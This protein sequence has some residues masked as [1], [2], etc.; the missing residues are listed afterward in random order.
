MPDDSPQTLVEHLRELRARLLRCLAALALVL[1]ALAPFAAKLYSLLARPLLELLP[2]EGALIAT[3]VASPFL[4]PF[5]L[6]LA[7]A[8]FIT[9]PYWL[10]QAWSFAA[11]GMYKNEKRF[12]AG[13]LISSVA[14]FY[15]GTAFAAF[16][17]LPLALNFFIHAAPGDVVVMT[18]I[19]HYLGFTL[20]IF[21]AFGIAFEIPVAVW[22]AI[23]TELASVE[24]CRRARPYV[25]VGCF[26]IGML[27]TPPDVISQILLALPAWLLYELGILAGRRF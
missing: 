20:K 14:L 6:I 22:L 13:L 1:L 9:A 24:G 3:E 16:A 11:P 21:L 18:D 8:V 25:I 27:L 10:H 7:L 23:R 12:G 17:V 2:E 15:L 5:K 26:V 4:A 19:S